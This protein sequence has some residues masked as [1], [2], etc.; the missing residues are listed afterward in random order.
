MKKE[1]LTSYVDSLPDEIKSKIK[2]TEL[3]HQPLSTHQSITSEIDLTKITVKEM[4]EYLSKFQDEDILKIE[5]DYGYYDDVSL[6]AQ[7]EIKRH[8]TD[9]EL[10]Q[11][12]MDKIKKL[13]KKNK[14]KP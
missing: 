6:D 7:V 8:E 11:R 9:D 14:P 5:I 1:E 12:V 4:K 10:T 13:K 2:K 3:E